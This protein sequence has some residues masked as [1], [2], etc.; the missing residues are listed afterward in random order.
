M[1]VL[2]LL[3]VLATLLL[4]MWLNNLPPFF[5]DRSTSLPWSDPRSD[6]VGDIL[7][8]AEEGRTRSQ[9]P[10]NIPSSAQLVQEWE[11]LHA[12][13]PDAEE[14]LIVCKDCF[15]EVETKTYEALKALSC[16]TEETISGGTNY[17]CPRCG[18]VIFE[19]SNH[20]KLEFGI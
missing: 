19:V 17:R 14:T 12:S 18:N 15:G 1:T 7:R 20:G 8:V 6:P 13:P 9:D 5:H 10:R 11:S 3:F 4:V 2:L 16:F